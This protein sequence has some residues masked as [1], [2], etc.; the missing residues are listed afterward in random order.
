MKTNE[1]RTKDEPRSKIE[2]VANMI[3]ARSPREILYGLQKLMTL[4]LSSD[5]KKECHSMLDTV[6]AYVSDSEYRQ[7]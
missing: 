4:P 2:L 5:F 7:N 3:G 1:A 6:R